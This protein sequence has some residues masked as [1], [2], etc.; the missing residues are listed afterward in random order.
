MKRSEIKR[1]EA[2]A[3]DEN[4]L[5]VEISAPQ[6]VTDNETKE[7][8]DILIAP[9]LILP[10]ERDKDQKFILPID[11]NMFTEEK[12]KKFNNFTYSI[13][14]MVRLAE[15]NLDTLFGVIGLYFQIHPVEEVLKRNKD[16]KNLE[17]YE[18]EKNF[19]KLTFGNLR[20]ILS[21]IVK[22]DPELCNIAGLTDS[23]SRS[24][25]TAVYNG[26][27][28]DRDRFTHGILFFKYPAFEP[29]LRIKT[30]TGESQYI[31]YNKEIFTHNLMTYDYL[32]S[33]LNEMRDFLQQKMESL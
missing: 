12:Y 7:L 22:T 31:T 33:I 9:T 32:T 28:E 3:I 4:S 21:C 20:N 11:P 24:N 27:I 8:V 13:G 18:I 6:K 15:L 1:P 29:I 26:Y 10:D 5:R 23:E 2:L 30:P 17:G 14:K 16:C 25:F 19:N